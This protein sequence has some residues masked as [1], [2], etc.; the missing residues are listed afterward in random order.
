M[1]KFFNPQRSDTQRPS[2]LIATLLKISDRAFHWLVGFFQLTEKEQREAGVY[3][4][5]PYEE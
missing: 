4:D 3:L 5:R 1:D 2:V